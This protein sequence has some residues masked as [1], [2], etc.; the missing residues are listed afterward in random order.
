MPAKLIDGNA[1][2]ATMR[3]ELGG[4]IAALRKQ[5]IKPGLAVV[6]VG[7]NPASEV[8]VRMKG[9]ACE[10]A[11]IFGAT[12]KLPKDTSEADPRAAPLTQANRREPRASRD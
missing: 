5:G 8:Y 9:K 10:E 7:E 4:E 3:A 12:I 11:G 1:I 6:L 2:G